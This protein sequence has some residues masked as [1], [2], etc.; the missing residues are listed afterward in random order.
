[1]LVDSRR[2]EAGLVLTRSNYLVVSLMGWV[3]F[4]VAGQLSRVPQYVYGLSF[5]VCY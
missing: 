5:P 2:L 1:M 3:G 4:Q